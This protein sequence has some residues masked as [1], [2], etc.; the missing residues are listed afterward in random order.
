MSRTIF[1][2]LDLDNPVLRSY[3]LWSSVLI[4]KTL[5]MSMLTAFHRFKNGVSACSYIS[6]MLN[7]EYKIIIIIIEIQYKIGAK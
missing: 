3:L 5:L 6:F 1:Q 2:I 4:I 7:I